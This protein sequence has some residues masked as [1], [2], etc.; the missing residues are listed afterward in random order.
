MKVAILNLAF[1][2]DLETAASLLA[3]FATL[4]SS[5]RSL[6]E[7]GASVTVLQRFRFDVD[8]VDHVNQG[9]PGGAAV[10]WHL[11]ADDPA[12]AF[13]GPRAR[14]VALMRIARD[15]A[16]AEVTGPRNSPTAE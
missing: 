4:A 5:S 2:R 8:H 11:R 1:D 10:R 12:K 9:D 6:A 13:A 7:A 15:L 14:P 16:P 3:R